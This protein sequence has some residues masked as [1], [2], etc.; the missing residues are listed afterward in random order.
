MYYTLFDGFLQRLNAIC[1]PPNFKLDQADA[2]FL[3]EPHLVVPSETINH[4]LQL[5][6]NAGCI[7]DSPGT[8]NSPSI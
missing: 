1:L 3:S 2:Q 7:S 8:G 4:Y 5:I 6:P